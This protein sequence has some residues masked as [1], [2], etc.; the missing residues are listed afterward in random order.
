VIVAN[1]DLWDYVSFQMAVDIAC[2]ETSPMIAAQNLLDCVIGY[3][4]VECITIM[5]IKV[6][7]GRPHP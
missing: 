2:K 1:R 4:A 6:G 3:G 5:A 7:S